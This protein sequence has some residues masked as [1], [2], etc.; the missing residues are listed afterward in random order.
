M[1]NCSANPHR[2]ELASLLARVIHR[3]L[4]RQNVAKS[5]QDCLASSATTLLTVTT[6]VN[7]NRD[8]GDA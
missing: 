3:L 6:T 1:N 4:T 5:R 8:Q 2:H 7:T